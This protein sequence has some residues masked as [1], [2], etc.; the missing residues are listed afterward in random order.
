MLKMLMFTAKAF[1]GENMNVDNVIGIVN[2]EA[3]T[4]EV[5]S[6]AKSRSETAFDYIRK[7]IYDGQIG[8]GA[9]INELEISQQLGISRGPVREAIRR[10]TSS[11]LLT[12]EPN[13]GARVITLTP[14]RVAQLY[15]VREALEA[16]AAALA[17]ELMTTEERQALIATLD[18]HQA[19]MTDD[20]STSY[21]RGSSDW[22]FHLLVL[23]GARNEVIWR[24]CGDELRDMFSL[25]RSQHGSSPGRGRRALEEHR[26]VAEAIERGHAD[27]ASMLMIQ[28]I[29]ASRD[30]LLRHIEASAAS[31]K[32]PVSR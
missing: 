18:A 4:G 5:D 29:R 28:H 24:I 11:G 2:N 6:E 8:P 30:N 23:K 12:F 16:K 26:W 17:A 27:L 14:E 9:R 25:L 31:K 13:A 3:G 20:N 21:P 10:M 15:D 19:Q 32:H 7:R 22:D 1:R